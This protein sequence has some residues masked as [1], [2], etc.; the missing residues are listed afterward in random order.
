MHAQYV[1]VNIHIIYIITLTSLPSRPDGQSFRK[2]LYLS[3]KTREV[4]HVCIRAIKIYG[5]STCR[6]Y[7]QK[8]TTAENS[9]QSYSNFVKIKTIKK[10]TFLSYSPLTA[11]THH[12]NYMQLSIYLAW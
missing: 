4:K 8:T 3:T 5:V 12:L 6:L 10:K 9:A 7:T 11:A 2:C 1:Y